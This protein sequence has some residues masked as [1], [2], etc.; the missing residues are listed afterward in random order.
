LA[1][2]TAGGID[3]ETN[4][5]SVTMTLFPSGGLYIG[6]SGID[7]GYKL[8]VV[9]NVFSEGYLNAVGNNILNSTSGNTIIGPSATTNHRLNVSG[10]TSIINTSTV[11]NTSLY[12]I[13]SSQVLNGSSFTNNTELFYA[14]SVGQLSVG[15]TGTFTVFSRSPIGLMRP[16]IL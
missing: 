6:V 16:A 10:N 12:S 15:T 1:N 3:F 4:G 2:Y 7:N 11:S 14:G 5:G 9:G 8:Q 13:M